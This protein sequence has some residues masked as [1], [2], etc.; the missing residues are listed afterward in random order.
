[1]INK[2]CSK[3]VCNLNVCYESLML[4]TGGDKEFF[5]RWAIKLDDLYF[6][7]YL[8]MAEPVRVENH[9]YQSEQQ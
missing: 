5:G 6:E 9:L 4:M 2:I 3:R 8:D 7:I 1:M